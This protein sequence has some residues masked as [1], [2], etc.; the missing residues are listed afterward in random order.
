M[1]DYK[2]LS[3]SE[4]AS[5]FKEGDKLAFTEI[6][7]RYWPPLVLH[8]NRMV[9]D[10]DL[11]KDTVQEVFTQLFQQGTITM[12]DTLPCYLYKA[13]RNRVLNKIKHEK[14]KINYA[15]D[16]LNYA[17][18][19]TNLADEEITFKELVSAIESEIEKMPAKM[20]EIFILSRKQHL[21]QKE[22]ARMLNL[23]E[24]TVNNQI[25]RA[26]KKLRQNHLLRASSMGIFMLILWAIKYFDSY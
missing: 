14:V 16:F 20:K 19:E 8:A 15:A 24:N 13:V 9:K 25:Q 18:N 10:E 26:L 23:S 3:D 22:I 5:L 1:A 12:H 6:Y 17:K 7:D 11:A 21:T 2:K 4:L